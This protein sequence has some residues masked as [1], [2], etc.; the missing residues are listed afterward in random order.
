MKSLFYLLVPAIILSSCGGDSKNATENLAALKKQR[1]EIDAKIRELESKDPNANKAKVTPVSVLSIEPTTFNAFIDV[2]SQI[3]G[4]E[5]VNAV[6][7]NQG[8]IS[9][10]FVHVGQHVS[11][12]QV[13]AVLDNSVAEQ[14]VKA[15]E[16]QIE[17]A[18]A[19]YEKQQKLWAQNI[20][21]EVQLITAKSTYEGLLKQKAVAQAGKDLNNIVAPISGTV[22]AVSMKVGDASMS[23]S[24][25]IRIVNTNKL[26]A[27]AALGENY[28]GKVKTGDQAFLI[29]PDVNDTVKTK[30]T[31]VARSVD[32][33]SRAFGVQVALP[34]SAGISPNMSCILRI[35]NYQKQDAIVIPVSIIQKTSQG[36]TV[37]VAEGN[38]SK[39]VTITTGRSSNG[40]VE[41][42]SGLQA[43]DKVIVAG[44]QDLDN[45]EP[46]AIQ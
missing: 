25:S 4:D 38:K 29:F 5:V 11:Q 42:L 9:K 17:M 35:A 21:T 36:E 2:Q 26:K 15:L 40:L 30:V 1:T 3:T 27:E 46:V 45:N 31:Y 7:R 14:Q 13:L 43:G 10:V 6:A 19:L 23:P 12:G 34:S 44:F 16:P 32:P 41:V 20:G 37:F 22:D 39:L 18:K 24:A 28:I 33:M 8:V